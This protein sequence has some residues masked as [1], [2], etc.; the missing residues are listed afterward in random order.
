MIPPSIRPQ[1]VQGSPSEDWRTGICSNHSN[2]P[3]CA[4]IGC[5]LKRDEL[6]R[7]NVSTSTIIPLSCGELQSISSSLLCSP[8]NGTSAVAVSV[9]LTSLFLRFFPHPPPHMKQNS[10]ISSGLKIKY[11][12][13]QQPP[14]PDCI[15]Q[16]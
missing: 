4:I 8:V 10:D 13:Q 9:M 12:P 3:S 14:P 1:I 7:I 11:P 16:A 2:C 15:K 6:I 5:Y